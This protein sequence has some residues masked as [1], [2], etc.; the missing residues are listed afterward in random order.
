MTTV[1]PANKAS[2]TFVTVQN[3][4]RAMLALLSLKGCCQLQLVEEVVSKRGLQSLPVP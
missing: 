4:A 2:N 3:N 1:D